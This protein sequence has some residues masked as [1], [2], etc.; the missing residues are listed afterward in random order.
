VDELSTKLPVT[1]LNI[2][3]PLGADSN[4]H[5]YNIC[6]NGELHK[7]IIISGNTYIKNKI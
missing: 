2:A 1:D 6:K 5:R 4:L 7:E 3:P